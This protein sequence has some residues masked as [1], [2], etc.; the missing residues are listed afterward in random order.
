MPAHISSLLAP[1]Y[2]WDVMRM[3]DYSSHMSHKL[4]S[5][6]VPDSLRALSILQGSGD[7]LR[8]SLCYLVCGRQA[9]RVAGSTSKL[10]EWVTWTTES[11]STCTS[12]GR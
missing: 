12:G 3:D 7:T 8:S 2:L 1:T 11:D 5:H 10:T 9:C 6:V 4:L